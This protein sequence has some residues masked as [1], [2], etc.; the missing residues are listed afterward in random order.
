MLYYLRMKACILWTISGIISNN[1][2]GNLSA[3]ASIIFMIALIA[4]KRKENEKN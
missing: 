4:E 2:A 3:V 1:F